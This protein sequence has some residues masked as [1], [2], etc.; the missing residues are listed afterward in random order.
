MKR[1]GFRH[2]W[3]C[4]KVQSLNWLAAVLVCLARLPPSP[5]SVPLSM[6]LYS[7]ARPSFGE[8][9]S[10]SVSPSSMY[11]P[12]YP[13]Y[14]SVLPYLYR[15][16]ICPYQSLSRHWA[17]C[18]R[19]GCG[20]EFR[21]CAWGHDGDTDRNDGSHKVGVFIPCMLPKAEG[22]SRVGV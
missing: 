7:S 20:E 15:S 9:V 3:R 13:A 2:C 18:V 5:S 6:S 10:L 21:N 12:T 19:C 16:V 17:G 22:G 1:K 4:C 11:L 14:P 8:L